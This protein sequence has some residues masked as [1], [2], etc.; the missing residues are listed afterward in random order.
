MTVDARL[1]TDDSESM[2]DLLIQ[3]A[4]DADA[5]T[6]IFI[7]G[8]T[9]SGKTDLAV[10]LVQ[11]FPCDIISVDS[12]L[13]Y[14]GMDIGTAKPAPE[15][16]QQAPHGLVDIIDPAESYS[17]AEF[18]RDALAA[19]QAITDAGRIPL[20]VGG[21]M[22]YYRAL[23]EGL[24]ELPGADPEVRRAIEQA[25][26]EQGWEAMHRRLAGVDPVAAQR[27]HPNDPQRIQRALEV[28]ETTGMSLTEYWRRQEP[29]RLPWRVIK[30]ALVPDDREVLRERIAVRFQQ[31]LAQ[32]FEAEVQGLMDR[33]DLNLDMP[34]M[35][36]VGY[37]QVWQYLEGLLERDDMV[38]RGITATRQLAKRQLTWLR[39]ERQCNYFVSDR[40][41]YVKIL[42]ILKNSL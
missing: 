8:P 24:S 21:T 28:Y 15:V 2:N 12:A 25:A 31:M 5:P 7:M 27:I 32:G 39:K 26:K 37:R 33:G 9:A 3:S 34:S 10:E 4:P 13:V 11:Q 17:A 6:A 42:K 23:Q 29:Y 20:L 19:M 16:L 38:F 36:C 30:I 22:L 40:K 18:R 1:P 41:I 14:R 35:R